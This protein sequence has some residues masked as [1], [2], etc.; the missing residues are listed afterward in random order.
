MFPL[1]AHNNSNQFEIV[2][3]VNPSFG[4]FPRHPFLLI[5]PISSMNLSIKSQ[6][7]TN[8]FHIISSHINNMSPL[9]HVSNAPHQHMSTNSTS[10]LRH[11]ILFHVTN[12]LTITQCHPIPCHQCVTLAHHLIPHHQCATSAPH[13]P[14]ICH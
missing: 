1:L 3:D 5:C 2:H 6:L 13:H 7:F 11:I 12:Y 9:C 4:Y 10:Q 14:I 8:H